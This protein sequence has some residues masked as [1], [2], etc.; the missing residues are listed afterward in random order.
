MTVRTRRILWSWPLR[1]ALLAIVILRLSIQASAS[2]LLHLALQILNDP[3]FYEL[4]DSTMPSL[5]KFNQLLLE[6]GLPPLGVHISLC[7]T[8]VLKAFYPRPPAESVP[9]VHDGTVVNPKAMTEKQDF[10]DETWFHEL[11]RAE[12]AWG[13]PYLIK[14]NCRNCTKV[15][16]GMKS[17]RI[18]CVR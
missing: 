18:F 2:F 7:L 14:K 8:Q 5:Y 10:A 15:L 9:T 1:N 12:Q 3:L 13:T 17:S 11:R 6:L 16:L 4:S